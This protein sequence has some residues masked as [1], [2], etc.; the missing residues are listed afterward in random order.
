M[1]GVHERSRSNYLPP[2]SNTGFG[3]SPYRGTSVTYGRGFVTGQ[4][5]KV[6]RNLFETSRQISRYK[7]LNKS[8]TLASRLNR[9]MPSNTNFPETSIREKNTSTGLETAT[10]FN[11]SHAEKAVDH[12]N[13]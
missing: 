9:V 3:K 7:N 11:F 13:S 1:V 10:K 5:A 6:K 4:V 12:I 2:S 8:G